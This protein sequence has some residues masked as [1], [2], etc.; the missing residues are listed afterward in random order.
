MDLPRLAERLRARRG[1]LA[2]LVPVV[3]ISFPWSAPTTSRSRGVTTR[4]EPGGDFAD[5]DPRRTRP[6][7]KYR[8]EI[9]DSGSFATARST[10]RRSTS[11]R[12]PCSARRSPR[13][14]SGGACRRSTPTTTSSPGALPPRWRRSPVVSTLIA[15][16]NAAPVA[17]TAPFSW[18]T[19]AAR[20]R[21]PARGLPQQRHDVLRSQPGPDRGHQ[22]SLATS[23]RSTSPASA[24]PYLWRVRWLDASDRQ[25]P[26]SD[27]HT[28]RVV[29]GAVQLSGPASGAYVVRNGPIL[30]WQP[31]GSAVKYQVAVRLDGATSPAVSVTTPATSYA[32]TSTLADGA[33]RVACPGLRRHEHRLD[34]GAGSSA[35]RQFKIDGTRPTVTSKSPVTSAKKTSNFTATFSEPVTGLTTSTMRLYV[36][37]RSDVTS[38]QVTIHARPYPR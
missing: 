32:T 23:R 1:G 38:R 15:P 28:F 17:G 18:E 20:I 36:S 4:H 34:Q 8:I 24:T 30:S 22:A 3:A 2:M 10:T 11:R 13:E 5:G 21:L 31:V 14:T 37:G 25:G 35:W 6:A 29:P 27:G 16:R 9:S 33:L 7:T 12:T 19:A 26:W